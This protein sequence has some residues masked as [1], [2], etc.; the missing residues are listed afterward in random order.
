MATDEERLVLRIE[1]QL[2]QFEKAMA[3][4]TGGA[5]RAAKRIETRFKTM[6]RNLSTVG[7]GLGRI[8]AVAITAQS[9]RRVVE[10]A[11][12]WT[13]AGNKIAAASQIAGRAG[14]SLS[15]I[16]KIAR[17]TRSGFTETAD[18][19]AK[20]LRA[21]ASVAE[22][23]E[24]V[25]RATELVNKAFKA[26]GAATS[27]QA[28]G[29]LQLS[30][31]LASGILQGD[32]L[33]SIRENAP[34][35]AAA[36]AKEFGTT[37]GG[38]KELGAEG[39]L[40]VD[41]VFK[42]I[43]AGAPE[44]EAA[45]ARTTGTIGD[46]FTDFRNRLT[47]SAGRI[48]EEFNATEN[49]TALIY[50][51][52]DA[53][54]AVTDFAIAMHQPLADLGAFLNVIANGIEDVIDAAKRLPSFSVGNVGA[55]RATPP[56]IYDSKGN[57]LFE[58]ET[59]QQP[60][61][62]IGQRTPDDRIKRAFYTSLENA[63]DAELA[64]VLRGRVPT[65]SSSGPGASGGFTGSGGQGRSPQEKFAEDIRRIQERTAAL[66][67][68]AAAVGKSTFEAEKMLAV[69]DLLNEAK[70]AGLTITPELTAQIEREAEAYATAN[71]R[72]LETEERYKGLQEAQNF[73]AETAFDAFSELIPVIETGNAALDKMIASLIQAAAQALLLGQ[74]PLAG[75]FGTATRTGAGG[76]I[77]GKLFGGFF[78][79][80]GTLGAGKWGIAGESGPEI[81][82]G[83]A[84]IAP[85]GAMGGAQMVE[86]RV[87]VEPSPLFI[88]TV[89]QTTQS[90]IAE[91][92]RRVAAQQQRY[93]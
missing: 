76:G 42:A 23:E 16:N 49:I 37:I 70:R 53:L 17:S 2:R 26:G 6:E 59:P 58:G 83:P 87:R 4:A 33:R 72:L 1:A 50:G 13:V 68:E 11:D 79:N 15:E 55:A 10:Y 65:P 48:N 30:Q 34:L 77:L 64:R 66:G 35:V 21:T 51:L 32:E 57:L 5:D 18:L 74:G 81:I 75:L 40:Q 24:E 93:G 25:A 41:R 67:V 38:L 47:E 14:R 84:R 45:F 71:E 62:P 29:I 78:A 44:I 3:Q 9:I 19:Y 88:T 54:E 7:A 31:A 39:K 12:E 56:R 73:F 27:E 63:G 85:M 69:Q 92:S 8:F 86:T 89:Q 91:N 61:S 60:K 90:A 46:A 80:G 43:L 82:R 52:G 20:L 22:N 36:I 28:A